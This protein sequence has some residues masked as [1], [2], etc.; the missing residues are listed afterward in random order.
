MAAIINEFTQNIQSRQAAGCKP[1]NCRDMVSNIGCLIP[2]FDYS[3]VLSAV[4]FIIMC[5]EH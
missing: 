5:E 1:T 3:S 2:P 4:G